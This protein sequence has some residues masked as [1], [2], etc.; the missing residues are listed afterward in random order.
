LGHYTE[1]GDCKLQSHRE[2]GHP[3]L[4]SVALNALA[5]T[6]ERK[7]YGKPIGEL[8]AIQFA[9]LDTSVD[10]EARKWLSHYG[11]SRLTKVQN[12]QAPIFGLADIGI[13]GD[14]KSVL[15]LLIQEFK[16]AL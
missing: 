2:R 5:F 6:K 8:Q 1:L 7:L 11:P 13:M 9:L 12:P 4:R 3:G 16:K 15:P 10:I 14:L